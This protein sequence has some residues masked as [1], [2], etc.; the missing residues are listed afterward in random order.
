MQVTAGYW[1]SLVKGAFCEHVWKKCIQLKIACPPVNVSPLKTAGLG[2][3][4]HSATWKLIL[5][6]CADLVTTPPLLPP[7]VGCFVQAPSRRQSQPHKK[8]SFW[9]HWPPMNSGNFLYCAFIHKSLLTHW[10][11]SVCLK[12]FF[13]GHFLLLSLYAFCRWLWSSSF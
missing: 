6:L 2:F 11:V 5:S 1:Q 9:I 3:C 13:M 7:F 4:L 10:A 12:R 8:S